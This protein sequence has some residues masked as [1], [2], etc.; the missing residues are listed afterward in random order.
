MNGKI[1]SLVIVLSMVIGSFGAVGTLVETNS[2]STE[3]YLP[4]E[5]IVRFLDPIDVRDIDSFGGN[6]IKN[7]IEALNV[8]V[9]EVNEGEEQAFI[10]SI[11]DSPFVKYA[12]LNGLVHA[13]F[14]PNDPRWNE[15]YGP[16]RINCEEAWDGVQGSADVLIAIVDTG[17]FHTH[18]DLS[19]NYDNRGYDW[20]NDDNNPMDDNSHGSHC[21]GIAAARINN[22]IGIAG[23]AGKCK[24][25]AEKVLSSG[26]SGSYDN[27]AKGIIDAADKG[28]HIIS[29]SLGGSNAQVMKDACDYAYNKGVLLVAASGNDNG[30][31]GYPA[32]Y[33]SVI[34]VGATDQSDKR[35]Y[36]SN[37]GSNLDL[38]AP[39][40][41]ILSTVLDNGYGYNTG[42][43]MAC[44][45]V[46]GVAALV[47]STPVDPDYDADGDGKW[48][49][50]EV[51]Q[52]LF[53]TAKD[54]GSSGKDDYYGYGLVD[55]AAAV[56]GYEPPLAQVTV[57]IHELTND[58][59]L[60][61]YEEIDT[62]FDI[63]RGGIKPEWYYRVGVKSGGETQYQFNYN[64]D[65][66][67]WWIWE[68]VW[69][70]TWKARQEHIFEVD[71]ISSVEVT[72]KLMDDDVVSGDDLADVSAYSGGG[73]NDDTSDKRGAIYHGTYNLKTNALTGDTVTEEGGYK[74]T[75]GAFGN[76]PANNAKVWFKI[77][78]DYE[79][80][81][82]SASSRPSP[83]R[84]TD[85]KSGSQ[86][87]GYI[88][89]KNVG[90]AGSKLDWEVSESL[91]W[92][93]C[94]PSS[95]H[96]L[97]PG[98]VDEIEVTVTAP[99]SG[100]NSGT[101]TVKNSEDSG[102][103]VTFDVYISVEKSRPRSLFFN[104]LEILKDQFPLLFAFLEQFVK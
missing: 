82:L 4:G 52:K 59:N 66:E 84:W 36:F 68:W 5:V 46:A 57:E 10:D 79:P 47:L 2:V 54:L 31:V 80:P 92:V 69:E 83:L 26:G 27:V 65:L 62:I 8:A 61:D 60:G 55:A 101:I 45:H 30:P 29:M 19:S 51:K 94:S 15:Q 16:R 72:I 7:K 13:L 39:G 98:Q 103:K 77:T 100:S 102:D 3:E 17:I 22:G 23:V 35:C 34:A 21:A 24:I 48:D 81:D 70:H 99:S 93:T 74:V 97:P 38:M 88:D 25:M 58:P 71:T 41:E 90:N 67:G 42:T 1:M 6:N 95:G 33:D 89:V 37:Y 85:V 63:T 20:V 43:S 64:K 53:D 9:V 76:D 11:S 32:A 78:D 18:N 40:D 75:E 91:S 49:N 12:E 86:K 14:T 44:P 28:A 104:F 87:I 56:D 96:N 50:N 73:R